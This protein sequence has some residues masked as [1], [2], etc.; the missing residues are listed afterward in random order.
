MRETYGGSLVTQTRQ[1]ITADLEKVITGIMKQNECM[2][3]PES[4]E[5]ADNTEQS[6]R[7]ES[8]E[9]GINTGNTDSIEHLSLTVALFQ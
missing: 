8:L 6:G 2:K 9:L 7:G 1:L 4:Q 3:D 5:S